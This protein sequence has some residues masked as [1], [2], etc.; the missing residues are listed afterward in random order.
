MQPTLIDKQL[1]ANGRN[2]CIILPS[3]ERQCAA[4]ASWGKRAGWWGQKSGS[5]PSQFGAG[6]CFHLCSSALPIQLGDILHA[7]DVDK[8]LSDVTAGCP[9]HRQWGNQK[10]KKVA[11]TLLFRPGLLNDCTDTAT[12]RTFVQHQSHLLSLYRYMDIILLPV[13]ILLKNLTPFLVPY[14]S[15]SAFSLTELLGACTSNV[16][17]LR[18]LSCLIKVV[19]QLAPQLQAGGSCTQRVKL[20]CKPQR[21]I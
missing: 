12:L 7:A 8:A 14:P 20:R 6:A 10:R 9:L 4:A 21:V 2:G 16:S 19:A 5:F 17:F 3:P 1:H 15:L 13:T 11:C 18:S